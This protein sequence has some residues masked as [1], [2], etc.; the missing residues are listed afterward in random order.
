MMKMI[1]NIKELAEPFILGMSKEALVLLML[2]FIM[3]L[4]LVFGSLGKMKRTFKRRKNADF[5]KFLKEY[6]EIILRRMFGRIT[7]KNKQL[8]L[9]GCRLYLEENKLELTKESISKLLSDNMKIY[10]NDKK[11]RAMY[12]KG[13]N[14]ES[15]IDVVY[16]SVQ[17][18]MKQG[19]EYE[20]MIKS[21]K[22]K[23]NIEM[24]NMDF[25]TNDIS[26]M[27]EIIFD[28]DNDQI[29]QMQLNNDMQMQMQNQ[30]ML[31]MQMQM[32]NQMMMDMQMQM[33]NQMIMDMQMQMQNQVMNDMQMQM[34]MNNAMT[35]SMNMANMA[36]TQTDFGGF[37]NN[38][39]NSGNFM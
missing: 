24:E 33:Q 32:Q 4:Y 1:H 26:N 15:I 35:D 16:K 18:G 11:I 10:K 25:S 21:I 9:E 19:P 7:G 31:D 5:E 14:A 34:Q 3:A 23:V 39:T 30:M 27:K 38:D 36:I 22:G 2:G 8:F 37:M 6:M 28:S 13:K 29:V 20:K 12:F 17:L